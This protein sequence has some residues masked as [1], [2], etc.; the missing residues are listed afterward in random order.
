MKTTRTLLAAWLMTHAVMGS[1]DELHMKNGSRLIGDLVSTEDGTITFETPFAG[2]ITVTLANVERV[3]TD[4]AVVI[5]LEDGTVYRDRRIDGSENHLVATLEGKDPVVFDAIDIRLINPAP[6]QLGEGYNWTGNFNAAL[7]SERGNSDTDEWDVAGRST[8]RSLRDRY[9]FDGELERDEA[10][11]TKTTDNWTAR[12]KYDRFFGGDPD[13]YWG[14]KLRF[15]YDKFLDLDLRTT[16]GPHIGRQFFD[17]KL[18]TLH[19]ELGPVWVDEQYDVGEDNDYP[20]ALWEMGLESGIIGFGTTV[21]VIHDGIL[22]FD[23][24]DALV[25]NTKVG[26]R[27]PLIYGFESGFEAKYEY[28]GGV[29]DDIDDMDE[30]YNFRI[31]YR[32]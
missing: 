21:Y 9:Q 27:M 26:L 1:A 11:N 10:D 2:S 7:E 31:G 17:S 12:L 16:V 6:W 5:M 19:A 20:G 23:E 22:N 25:L 15:E 4:E 24:T 29:E 32:W 14:G 8:W 18:L 13:N 28:D 30:T 3:V